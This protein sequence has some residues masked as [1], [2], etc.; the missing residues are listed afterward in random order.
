M[1]YGL[2]WG[3]NWFPRERWYHI[4][5]HIAFCVASGLLL[6]HTKTVGFSLGLSVTGFFSLVYHDYLSSN[7]RSIDTANYLAAMDYFMIV[8]GVVIGTII[9][10]PLPPRVSVEVWVALGLS[11]AV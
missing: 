3:E 7:V 11:I 9:E 5:S 6:F 1:A 10:L 2:F 8:V 4:V